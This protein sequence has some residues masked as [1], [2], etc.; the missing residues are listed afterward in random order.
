MN[1]LME[2]GNLTD[3]C[4]LYSQICH[5]CQLSLILVPSIHCSCQN[6]AH[7]KQFRAFSNHKQIQNTLVDGMMLLINLQRE[8]SGGSK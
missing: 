4:V 1:H 2:H 8:S 6:E 3:E 7:L 5:L